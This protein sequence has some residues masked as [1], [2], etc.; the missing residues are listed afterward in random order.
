MEVFSEFLYMNLRESI[1]QFSVFFW[2]IKIIGASNLCNKKLIIHPL[3]RH[4]S[5]SN[6]HVFLQIGFAYAGEEAEKPTYS[7]C[8]IQYSLL[9]PHFNNSFTGGGFH[10]N[11]KLWLSWAKIENEVCRQR[12]GFSI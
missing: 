10:R 3:V 2:D 4:T 8:T 6:R 1:I 11:M 5:Y 12:D 9:C 7:E